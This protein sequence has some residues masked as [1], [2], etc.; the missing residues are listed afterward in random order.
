MFYNPL[1]QKRRLTKSVADKIDMDEMFISNHYKILHKAFISCIS[2]ILWSCDFEK[3]FC[4]LLHKGKF[5]WMRKSGSTTTWDTGPS[6]A[7]SGNYY[8][9]TEANNYNNAKYGHGPSAM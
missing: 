7:A 2:E 6:R 8:I 9:Y 1:N 4:G 3:D 5:E